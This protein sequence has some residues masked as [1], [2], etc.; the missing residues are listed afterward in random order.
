MME[1]ETSGGSSK[2]SKTPICVIAVVIVLGPSYVIHA[3]QTS[4]FPGKSIYEV[5]HWT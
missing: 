2:N 5:T 3:I 1:T 4:K